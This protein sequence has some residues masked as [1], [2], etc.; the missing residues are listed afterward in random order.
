MPARPA[1]APTATERAAGLPTTAGEPIDPREVSPPIEELGAEAGDRLGARDL[2]PRLRF[3]CSFQKTSSVTIDM[4]HRID[5]RAPA[6]ST[7]TPTCCSRRPTRPATR[8]RPATGSSS[9]ASPGSASTSRRSSTATSSGPASPTPAAGS[10]RSSRCGGRSTG[11]TAGSRG[12]AGGL[13]DAGRRR[14]V[15][16]GQAVRALEAE[17]ARRLDRPRVWDYINEHEIPYNPLHDAGYPSIGCTPLHPP[18]GAGGDPR[19]GPL[20]RHRQDRVRPARLTGPSS[21]CN[22][23]ALAESRLNLRSGSLALTLS[24]RQTADFE[25][26]ANGGFAPLKGFM[27]SE[28]WRSRVRGHALAD[29]GR[30]G[31]SRSRSPPTSTS[32]RATSSRSAPRTASASGVTRRGGLRARRREGGGARLPDDRRRAPRRRRHPRRRAP[33]AS[34]ARSRPTRCPT[35]TRRSCAAT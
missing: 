2:P 27:G 24:A 28:D 18:P 32:A 1:M 4:V 10:A 14:Q 16:L 5:A 31:R 23:L 12:S 25:L 17:P 19:V 22:F 20:G 15:R 34:P 30:S 11:S 33:A 8:S 9:S 3:A 6:S 7:S 35:T 26:L 13:A 21:T 29:A